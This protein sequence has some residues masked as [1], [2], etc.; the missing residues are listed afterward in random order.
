[1]V[2]GHAPRSQPLRAR[3]W[4]LYAQNRVLDAVSTSLRS[5]PNKQQ[6]ECV[7]IVGLWCTRVAWSKW[8]TIAQAVGIIEHVDAQLSV[9]PPCHVQPTAMLGSGGLNDSAEQS[10]VANSPILK[11]DDLVPSHVYSNTA[12]VSTARNGLE[13]R[14]DHGRGVVEYCSSILN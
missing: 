14:Y 11:L 1:M 4:D 10:R 9:L 12:P 8:P 7:L 2:T 13:E 3:V 6:M 5:E